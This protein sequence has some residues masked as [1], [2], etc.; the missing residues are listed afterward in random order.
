MESRRNKVLAR[1][2]AKFKKEKKRDAKLIA[3]GK[4]PKYWTNIEIVTIGDDLTKWYVRMSGLGEPYKNG[5]YI[6]RIE[7]DKNHPMKPP[8]YYFMTP[9][10]FYKL[11]ENACISIGSYHSEDYPSVLG[12]TGFIMNLMGAMLQWKTIGQG[13]SLVKTS[14]EE[15]QALADTSYDYN[16]EH[17]MEIISMFE[18]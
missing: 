1:E 10:G 7:A 16:R 9:N 12:M 2:F 4:P 18:Q 5:E 15:K 6:I 8:K 14:A 13:I 11:G 17:H 3:S